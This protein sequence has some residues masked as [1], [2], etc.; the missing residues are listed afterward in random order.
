MSFGITL[1]DWRTRRR[2]SQMSLA[3]EADISTRH[4]CCLETG[5]SRPSR[6][7]IGRLSDALQIPRS[8]RN[9]LLTAAGFSPAYAKR[10][11][12][13][14]D[15][16]AIR[17]A[18]THMLNSHDP[19]P[20]FALD[21]HWRL[22]QLNQS[23]ERLIGAFGLGVGS[24][25]LDAITGD[26]PVAQSIENLSEVQ[27]HMRTRLQAESAHFGGD[28]VLEAA[29]AKL[30]DAHLTH[31]VQPAIIPII[32]KLGDVRLSLFSV[33][34]GFS[35]VEDIAIADMKVELMFPSD[36]A[37]KAILTAT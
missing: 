22:T 12:D 6:E 27:A 33:L 28:P 17:S 37:T 4:L 9:T 18:V 5:K 1:R 25:M 19:Y 8:E 14:D 7:M 29:R 21:R 15:L 2:H 10:R 13:S 26:S 3:L 35:S 16:S 20:A 32:F 36:D 31:S 34:A 23:A 30:G 24:S 11:W